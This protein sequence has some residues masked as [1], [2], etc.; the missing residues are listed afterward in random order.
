MEAMDPADAGRSEWRFYR[1]P[2]CSHADD[3][4]FTGAGAVLI[5]CSYCDTPLE[6]SAQGRRQFADARVAQAP[7]EGPRSPEPAARPSPFRSKATRRRPVPRPR[8]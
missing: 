7:G 2:V 4:S 3:V 1:C 5:S 6:I 8:P